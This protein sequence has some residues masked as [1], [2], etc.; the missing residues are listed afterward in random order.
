MALEEFFHRPEFEYSAWE[1]SIKVPGQSKWRGS[2][3]K[4]ALSAME[5]QRLIADP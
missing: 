3:H 4:D 2:V 5:P 1:K